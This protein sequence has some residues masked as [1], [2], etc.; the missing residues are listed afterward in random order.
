MQHTTAWNSA[1]TDKNR[2]TG[3]L[4]YFGCAD[5]VAPLDADA[6]SRRAGELICRKQWKTVTRNKPKTVTRSPGKY[7]LVA[8]QCEEV[9][10]QTHDPYAKDMLTIAARK[11]RQAA[12]GLGL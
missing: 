6:F 1:P 7:R 5:V 9:A 3:L 12:E 2:L 8:L 10:A 4:Q 11:L